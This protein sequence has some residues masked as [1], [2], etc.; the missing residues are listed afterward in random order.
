MTSR[1]GPFTN[2]A[3][4][5]AH[6]F[7]PEAD[8]IGRDLE[9]TRSDSLSKQ[10]DRTPERSALLSVR[11]LTKQYPGVRALNDVTFEI[12]QGEVIALLGPNGAGKTT[13]L[14]ILGGL[15]AP[16]GGEILI[17][18]RLTG[19]SH[20]ADAIADGIV[21]VTQEPELCDDLSVLENVWL[22]TTGER[23]WR[24]PIPRQLTVRT[25]LRDL[26]GAL[27][28]P[29][30]DLDGP[31]GGLPL[32]TRQAIVLSRAFLSGA[33]L[34]LLDEPMTN[35]SGPDSAPVLQAI[36]EITGAGTSVLL[37]T[38]R[39]DLAS[40]IADKILMLRDGTL[41]NDT[42]D[43]ES[44]AELIQPPMP[45]RVLTGVPDELSVPILELRDGSAGELNAICLSVDAGEIVA[46]EGP[47]LAEL[48]LLLRGLA[49]LGSLTKGEVF[50]R[51][52]RVLTTKP[53]EALAAGIAY[54]TPDRRGEGI[55][56]GLSITENISIGVVRSLANRYGILFPS[57][58]VEIAKRFAEK[59]HLVG[60]ALSDDAATLSG[61]NQQRAVLAR[62][63]ATHP[64]VLLL[65]NATRGLDSSGRGD[66][67]TCINTFCRDG[68]A[69][70]VSAAESTFLSAIA[71]RFVLLPPSRSQTP[72][73]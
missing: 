27:G 26:F 29:K 22:G 9:A 73:K 62:V 43:V 56:E 10:K 20:P 50:L 51:G 32:A 3:G 68:G 33:R 25:Q 59:L 35:L 55:F 39:L 69:C 2:V 54:V 19:H 38:H 44:N 31:C 6:K 65:D 67:A 37:S 36:R 49:G 57:A 17:D 45:R 14:Q 72:S 13:L 28:L 4:K 5:D 21:L 47:S 24:S 42:R 63:M 53:A 40:E 12:A 1:S 8:S 46:L 64:S 7:A 23:W 41:V 52:R 16:D 60:P 70:I 15:T 34:L 58:E 48:S 71:D 11:A 61:G 30:V 66:L 18:G